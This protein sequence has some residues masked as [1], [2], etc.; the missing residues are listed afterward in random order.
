MH[1]KL[2]MII[3]IYRILIKKYKIKIMIKVKIN[4]KNYSKKIQKLLKVMNN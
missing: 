2:E 4:I 3:K 1:L